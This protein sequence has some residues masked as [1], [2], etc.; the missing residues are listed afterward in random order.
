MMKKYTFWKKTLVSLMSATVF[1]LSAHVSALTMQEIEQQG[2]LKVV[3]E[4]NYS[5][6]NFMKSGKPQGFNNDLLSDLQAY[7]KDKFKV[8]QTIMPWT[9]LLASVTTGQYNLAITG[10]MA[11][12]ERAKVLSFSMPLAASQSVY[13]KRAKDSSISDIK[14]LDGKTLGVQSGTIFYNHLNQLEEMLA[15]SGGKIGKIIQ[16][17]SYPEAYADLANGRVDYVINSGININDLIKKRGK[18]FAKGQAVSNKDYFCWPVAKGNP[19][20]LNYLDKF[21][22]HEK[23]IGR[24][25]KLQMKWFGQTFDDLPNQH[26]NEQQDFQLLQQAH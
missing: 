9:G 16:Y 10:A 26:V 5:P 7:S 6:F 25:A 23:E 12:E 13:V 4:D 21:I 17:Q 1:A 20:L 15:V 2:V 8:E 3:T 14:S 11:T 22:Q 19:E 18:I 24:L